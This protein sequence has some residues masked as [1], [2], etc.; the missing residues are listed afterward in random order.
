MST[1]ISPPPGPFQVV[2]VSDSVSMQ[3]ARTLLDLATAQL[4]AAN[5]SAD[6]VATRTYIDEAGDLR[7]EGLTPEQF[8]RQI[9]PELADPRPDTRNPRSARRAQ[10]RDWRRQA[11]TRR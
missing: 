8:F 9:E 6:H 1:T 2:L 5:I 11:K 7:L 4:L 3:M 10:M